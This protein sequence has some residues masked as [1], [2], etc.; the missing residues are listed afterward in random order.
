MWWR[1]CCKLLRTA[2]N[3][4][5]TRQCD[6]LASVIIAGGTWQQARRRRITRRLQSHSVKPLCVEWSFT[7]GLSIWQ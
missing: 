5:F 7:G 4:A 3:P 2:I 6:N 1:F